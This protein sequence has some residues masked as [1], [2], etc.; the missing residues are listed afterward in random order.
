MMSKELGF[1]GRYMLLLIIQ[2]LLC[3]YFMMSPYMMLTLLPAMV[4]SIP[5]RYTTPQV[6]LIAFGTALAVDFLADGVPGLNV[7]AL[8]PVAFARKTFIRWVFGTGLFARGE[9]FSI[10][11][12]GL[13]KVSLVI[14]L[15]LTLFLI[16]YIWVDGSGMRPGW[17]FFARFFA[18][19]PASYL[20]SLLAI[21]YFSINDR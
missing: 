10:H 4:L 18:S 11:K 1:F 7:V 21:I 13:G 8:L 9:D 3:N 2:L 16:L 17:F 20:L 14:L 19:L 15:S 6:L 12:N 5:L